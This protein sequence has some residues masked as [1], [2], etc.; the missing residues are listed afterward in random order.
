M[1]PRGAFL[2][3]SSVRPRPHLSREVSHALT[4][5]LRAHRSIVMSLRPKA[6]A[7]SSYK[8]I[9]YLTDPRP[10]NTTT[11]FPVELPKSEKL[12][13]NRAFGERL[14]VSSFVS[15]GDRKN[16]ASAWLSEFA[17]AVPVPTPMSGEWDGAVLTEV[18]NEDNEGE[19]YPPSERGERMLVEP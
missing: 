16:V 4:K 1:T 8:P 11:G 3:E 2:F 12:T 5:R 17:S 10:R 9:I 13:C 18:E 6:S 15:L 14:S 7:I 19:R